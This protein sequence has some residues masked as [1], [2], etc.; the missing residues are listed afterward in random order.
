MTTRLRLV[1]LGFGALLAVAA[2]IAPGD[3]P[4]AAT[5]PTFGP[6]ATSASTLVSRPAATSIGTPAT[7]MSTATA[8]PTRA[9]LGIERYGSAIAMDT[10]NNYQVG[11]T[12]HAKVSYRFR[13]GTT[14]ALSAVAVNQRGGAGYSGGNGGT[15]KVTVQTDKAGLP[16]GTVLASFTFAPGNPRGTWENQR[17]YTFPSPAALTSGKLYHVV[18]ENV[19]RSLVT[20]YVSLN[21]GYTYDATVP[22]QPAFSDDFAVLH[23][24]GSGWTVLTNDT[25]VIDLTYADGHHDGNAYFGIV[26]DYYVVISGASHMAR[27]RFTVSGGDRTVRSV[28]VR[29]KRIHGADPL[30]IRIQTP[31]G[32]LIAFGTVGAS[33]I[34]QSPLP[35]SEASLAGSRWMTVRFTSPIVLANGETYDLLLSTGVN[36]E[37][38]AIPI[39]EQDATNPHWASRAFRDGSAQRTRDGQ[40]WRD[41]YARAPLDL[42]FYFQ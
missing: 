30:T 11:W 31:A 21:E 22:R 37:Y 26:A 5:M 15:I 8:S 1:A 42:Q 13:A 35:T 27:E 2:M 6:A 9:A 7:P 38:V 17:A 29:Y 20:N 28:A 32:D 39:R 34:K 10:K 23:D 4:T 12:N 36:T 19:N 24:N 41:V 33:G 25:P 3:A 18:F 40:T 16:S 14:S